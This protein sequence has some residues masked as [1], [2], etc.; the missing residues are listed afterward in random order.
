M[1]GVEAPNDADHASSRKAA[2]DYCK[3]VGSKYAVEANIT[4]QDI[5][6]LI[7]MLLSI[8]SDCDPEIVPMLILFMEGRTSRTGFSSRP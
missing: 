4:T 6:T 2:T 3:S 7:T 5:A 1:S 8:A